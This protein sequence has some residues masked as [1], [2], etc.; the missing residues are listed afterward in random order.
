M[1]DGL[2]ELIYKTARDFIKEVL[3][4]LYEVSWSKFLDRD[5]TIYAREESKNMFV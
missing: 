2:M 1:G 3:S 4:K 5:Y